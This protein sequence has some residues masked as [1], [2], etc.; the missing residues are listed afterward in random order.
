[1]K[2]GSISAM[3]VERGEILFMTCMVRENVVTVWEMVSCLIELAV[4]RDVQR[5]V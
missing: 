2:R 1:M 5:T 3:E 4:T